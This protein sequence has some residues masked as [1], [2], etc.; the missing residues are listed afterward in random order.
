M[1][2]SAPSAPNPRAT[3]NGGAHAGTIDVMRGIRDAVMHAVLGAVG[4][5]IGT[6][7]GVAL[8]IA[9]IVPAALGLLAF[10]L[11][12]FRALVDRLRAG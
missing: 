8:A 2:P 12:P 1:R 11:S 6:L 10:L 3:A 7:S 4:L 9:A 5:V